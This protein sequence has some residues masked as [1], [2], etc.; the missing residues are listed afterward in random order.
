MGSMDTTQRPALAFDRS[1]L[2]RGVGLMAVGTTLFVVGTALGG[3]AVLGACRRYLNQI[4]ERP[5]ELARRQWQ[6]LRGSIAVVP[7]ADLADLQSAG[8]AMRGAHANTTR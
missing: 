5:T 1:L 4:E 8:N 2:R 3:A 7:K 6:Q